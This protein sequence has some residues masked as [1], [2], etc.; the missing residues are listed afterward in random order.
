MVLY[1]SV[2]C[3][4]W[5]D[6]QQD[7]VGT[8]CRLL[9][10]SCWGYKRECS[11]QHQTLD[12]PRSYGSNLPFCTAINYFPITRNRDTSGTNTHGSWSLP[13]NFRDWTHPTWTQMFAFYHRI[14]V[15]YHYLCCWSS[16]IKFESIGNFKLWNKDY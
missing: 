13:W 8:F 6:T 10:T 9:H 5:W 12:S 11:F 1:S 14:P 7:N 2:S 15:L 4:Q 3:N 16:H